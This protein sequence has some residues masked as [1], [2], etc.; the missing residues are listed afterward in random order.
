MSK[1]VNVLNNVL[2]DI[3]DIKDSVGS[4]FPGMSYEEGIEA[5]ILW[6]Q[7]EGEHPLEE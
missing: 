6:I 4:K 2:A 7:G 1:S 5:A 3:A